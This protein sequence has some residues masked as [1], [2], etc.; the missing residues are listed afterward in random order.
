[1]LSMQHIMTSMLNGYD[2]C[3]REYIA[4]VVFP[5]AIRAFTG[6]RELSH[7]EENPKTGDISWMRFPNYM[8][9]DKTFMEEWKSK[10]FLC[11]LSNGIEKGVLGQKTHIEKYREINQL[12]NLNKPAMYK[13]IEDHLKQDIVYDKYVRDYM[14]ADRQA[15]FKDEDHAIYVA[16][17]LIYKQRGILC[18]KEWLQ[19]E[20]KPILEEQM[21][22]L[23]ENTFKYMHFTDSKYEKWV[24]DQDWSHLD[25]GPFPF[26]QYE[27]LYNDVSLFMRQG[28]DPTQEQSELAENIHRRKGR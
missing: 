8:C 11:H 26:E 6:E 5:D 21:P 7:F 15:I 16:A 24:E 17:Y 23:A 9:V 10:D 3:E 25:E 12:L 27:K 4:A 2:T 13:G 19:N 18:N 1:M 28:I 20:I 14:G 22:F